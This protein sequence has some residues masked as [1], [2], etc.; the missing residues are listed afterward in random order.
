[1]SKY[2]RNISGRPV[3]AP[4]IAGVTI[5][6]D[7]HG[8]FNLNALHK[9]SGLGDSKKPSEWLSLKGTK[10]LLAELKS[11]SGDL[12][13]GA[14][15]VIKGGNAPGTFAHELLAISYAGWISPAFQLQVNQ[16]FLDYRTGNLEP[17]R[18][19]PHL[20]VTREV[21]LTMNQNLRL[22]KML[23]LDGNQAVLSANQA[24]VAMTGVDMMGLLG[25]THVEAPQN[26]ALLT[27]TQIGSRIGCSNRAVNH[28]LTARGLQV[29]FTDHKGRIYYEPTEAGR[30]AGGVMQDTGKKHG[31]GTPV[32]QLKWSSEII[33]HLTV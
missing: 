12:R 15:S 30:L 8:R 6:T 22:A 19:Y 32:R 24:T 5:T 9:A 16:V 25:V 7:A 10:E 2:Q 18:D 21:R 23:G 11:Q 29:A 28:Q 1:M 13:F 26:A 14:L 31:N 20:D 27:P 3:Q 33:D 4:V 17:Q